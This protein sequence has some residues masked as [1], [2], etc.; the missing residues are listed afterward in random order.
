MHTEPQCA[1]PVQRIDEE[2]EAERTGE[3]SGGDFSISAVASQLPTPSNKVVRLKCNED[4]SLSVSSMEKDGFVRRTGILFP[5]TRPIAAATFSVP[6][7]YGACSETWRS[8]FS[9]SSLFPAKT[10]DLTSA[11]S[12]AVVRLARTELQWS[13]FSV[14]LTHV[15]TLGYCLSME[16]GSP[17]RGVGWL[18]AKPSTS[19]ARRE[20]A[21]HIVRVAHLGVDECPKPQVET[22]VEADQDI[23]KRLRRDDRYLARYTIV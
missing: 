2:T 8:N 14:R 5:C 20:P 9:A 22:W 3:S 4:Q 11:M 19:F 1:S 18:E 12:L 21:S 16:T 6:L 17:D 23:P 13:L 7:G 15:Y 10:P